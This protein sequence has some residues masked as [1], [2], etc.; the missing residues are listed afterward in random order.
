MDH[1]MNMLAV[2][3]ATLMPMIVGFIYYHPK[4]AAWHVDESKWLYF[5]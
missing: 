1:K 5:G 3:V 4:V 2:A